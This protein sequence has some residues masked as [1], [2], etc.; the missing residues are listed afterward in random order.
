MAGSSLHPTKLDTNINKYIYTQAMHCTDPLYS[1]HT[2]K[3]WQLINCTLLDDLQCK[4]P[5]SVLQGTVL[6]TSDQNYTF[7]TQFKV[8]CTMYSPLHSAQ[9]PATSTEYKLQ[10]TFHILFK[11]KVKFSSV[12]LWKKSC[13]D[14]L[15]A[16]TIYSLQSPTTHHKSTA[17]LLVI[18][19]IKIATWHLLHEQGEF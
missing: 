11:T 19:G 17:L 1:V 3:M 2:R 12:Y 7:Y 15:R 9:Q 14:E 10:C 16:A 8:H 5:Y 6:Y 18:C 4:H 13:G